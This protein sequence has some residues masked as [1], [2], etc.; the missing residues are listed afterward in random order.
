MDQRVEYG[1]ER[2]FGPV[3]FML[4][5]KDFE[6]GQV[7]RIMTKDQLG[8]FK[9]LRN[10]SM[11]FADRVALARDDEERNSE[12]EA[13]NES[14]FYITSQDILFN[15]ELSTITYFKD[16]TFGVLFEQIKAQQQL[17]NMITNTL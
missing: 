16:I 2:S 11:A 6:S 3:E 12:S 4:A 10:S 8:G 1:D 7:Y 13:L 5:M 15:D 14:L 17:Q 9:C